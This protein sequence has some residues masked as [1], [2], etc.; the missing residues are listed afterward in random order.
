M[1]KATTLAGHAYT[2]RYINDEK[3]TIVVDDHGT[4]YDPRCLKAGEYKEGTNC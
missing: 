2:L 1:V 3:G 4:N